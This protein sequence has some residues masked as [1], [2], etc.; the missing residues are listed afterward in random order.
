[1]HNPSLHVKTIEDKLQG[2]I[3][4]NFGQTGRKGAS[5]YAHHGSRTMMIQRIIVAV[6]W[7]QRV[8]PTTTDH[9]THRLK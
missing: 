7:R 1:M 5:V 6:L 8:F 4:M 9:A 2:A 3:G